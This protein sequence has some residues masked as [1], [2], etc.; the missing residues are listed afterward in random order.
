MDR[1]TKKQKIEQLKKGWK[2]GK[3]VAA[4][5]GKI[6]VKVGKKV[7]KAGAKVTVSTV[8]AGYKGARK[9]YREYQKLS[10]DAKRKL[11]RGLLVAG[12]VLTIAGTVYT[13]RYGGF[14]QSESKTG[15]STDTLNTQLTKTYKITDE[16]SFQQLYED[17]LPL[18]Q[19][20][21]IPIEIYKSSGY[22]DRGGKNFNS[23]GIGNFYYPEDG[24]PENSEWIS[25]K[26]YLNAHPDTK[27]GFEKALKLVDAWYRIRKQGGAKGGV[28]KKMYKKLQGAELT[29]H[30]FAAIASCTYNSEKMGFQFCD[31]VR[32]HYQNP[33]KCAHYL[34]TLTPQ[35]KDCIDGILV[36]HTAEAC[37]YMYPDYAA[38]VFHFKMKDCINSKGKHHTVT[39]INQTT[40]A[41]GRKVRDDLSRGSTVQLQIH[42][43]RIMKYMCKGSY[44]VAD[45]VNR[46]IKDEQKKDALLCLAGS[47]TISFEEQRADMT[48]AQALEKYKSG[49]YKGA[50]DGFRQLRANGYDGA[51]LRCDIALTYYHLKE[52]NKCIEECR[53]VLAT[54]EEQLYPYATYNAGIAYEAMENYERAKLNYERSLLMADKNNMDI[55]NKN[56]YRDAVN[57]MDS[58]IK[59]RQSETKILQKRAEHVREKISQNKREKQKTT[60]NSKPQ[61]KGKAQTKSKQ[62]KHTRN[63]VLQQKMKGK[64]RGGR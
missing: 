8:R 30:Q 60:V 42:K 18:I 13:C 47:Q 5:V 6:G 32:G 24:N 39:S 1:A 56:I 62:Q 48:Y 27:V 63:K 19:A 3:K 23:I 25:T 54:G 41:Q 20:S 2:I 12:S 7:A 22:D 26:K 14:R 50:L 43:N 34:T 38:S 57:R 55:K 44:T 36:R 33:V 58:I 37:L 17:A 40:P 45:L 51:D 31:Y 29:I 35:K 9:T 21:M 15:V 64:K 53:A 52:Y 46:N 61:A 11:H 10:K 4:A 59:S 16:A 49:D 28:Y